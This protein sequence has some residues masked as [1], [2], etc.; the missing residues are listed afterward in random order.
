MR[1]TTETV[2]VV[3]VIAAMIFLAA[4]GV[5]LAGCFPMPVTTTPDD[6]P[7]TASDC[8]CPDF[9]VTDH[10]EDPNEAPG[11]YCMARSRTGQWMDAREHPQ[12]Q[13]EVRERAGRED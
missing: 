4:I 9:A 13:R 1:I 11:T 6:A 5:A 3:Y 2:K 10:P 8:P 7:A 12:C